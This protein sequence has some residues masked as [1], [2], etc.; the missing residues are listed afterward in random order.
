MTLLGGRTGFGGKI[1]KRSGIVTVL[2]VG[3]TKISC[4][5]ARLTPREESAQLPGRTHKI[6]VLGI[7]HQRSRGVKSGASHRP[8]SPIPVVAMA[9]MGFPLPTARQPSMIRSSSAATSSSP[10]VTTPWPS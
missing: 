1:G 10:S 5:I 4:M 2:D 8:S 3:S 6:E 9:A 7:G